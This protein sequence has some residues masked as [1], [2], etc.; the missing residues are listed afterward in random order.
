VESSST[1]LEHSIAVAA[2][3]SA[4]FRVIADA[5]NWPIVFLPT[6]HLDRDDL[7]GGKERIHVW[8]LANDEVKAW[9]SIRD[10]DPDRL[11]V[12]FRQEKSSPPIGAMSGEWIVEA[13]P[14]GGSLVRLL[15]D[16]SAIDDDPAALQWIADATDRNS[17]TELATLKAAA[18][19]SD[20]RDS[21]IV[22]WDDSVPSTGDP[23]AAWEFMWNAREWPSR[24]PHVERMSLE[25]PEPNI[26][27][28]EM[29]TKT[30]DGS[31]HTTKS[32]RVGFPMRRLVYK[33]T[34]PPTL[35]SV[36][37]GHFL[38]EDAP[39]GFLLTSRHTA[40]IKPEA[41][42]QVLGADATVQDARDFIQSALTAN[43]R[44]TMEHASAFAERAK[45]A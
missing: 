38:I 22:Q 15:H 42:A 18:E 25:E 33:Q 41:I 36:H 35:L 44:V 31:A 3:P 10:L 11:T 45:V 8:A 1:H 29:D 5:V 7:G 23:E 9:T 4:A 6:I 17:K 32:I 12:Q 43:S 26:Q 24:V 28:M 13:Q 40:M 34:T 19:Q 37:T 39:E 21:L 27:L 16:F 30:K 2:A 20:E 14:D